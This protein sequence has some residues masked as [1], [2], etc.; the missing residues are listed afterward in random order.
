MN[1]LAWNFELPQRMRMQPQLALGV[2]PIGLMFASFVPLFFLSMQVAA[3]LGISENVPVKDQPNATMGLILF[4]VAMVIFMISG[5]LLGWVLNAIALRHLFKWPQEKVRRVLLYSEV[6]Q[7][8]LKETNTA[9]GSASNNAAPNS[10]WAITRQKGRWNFIF[11]R[12]VLAWGLPMYLLMAVLPTI[13]G[14]VEPTAFNFLWQACLWGAAGALFGLVI[15]HFS[16]KSF[17]KQYGKQE[18]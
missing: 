18:P 16:E 8:W 9:P 17:L 1:P 11:Q 3:V 6:P 13:N 10:S 15:W 7:E 2:L 5:Y 4:L 14:R 12:G